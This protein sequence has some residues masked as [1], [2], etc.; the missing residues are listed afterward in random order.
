MWGQSSRACRGRAFAEAGTHLA[1]SI[2]A[3][4]D[5]RV[6]PPA[7]S[8]FYRVEPGGEFV[9]VTPAGDVTVRTCF[10][11]EVAPMALSVVDNKQRAL[12]ALG[13][14]AL[15][16]AVLVTVYEGRVR[17]P[18][19]SGQGGHELQAGEHAQL[20]SRSFAAV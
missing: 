8:V 4:G 10:R 13:G 20:A 5:V 2:S 11:V 19:E 3:A 12:F 16:S 6:S 14:A 15:A 7:G 9:I 1:W 17:V 18:T